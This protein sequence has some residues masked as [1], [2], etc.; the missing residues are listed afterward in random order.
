MQSIKRDG[1]RKLVDVFMLVHYSGGSGL[2]ANV[3][4][5]LEKTTLNTDKNQKGIEQ[6]ARCL[7]QLAEK[8]AG[9]AL[10]AVPA[11]I[12]RKKAIQAKNIPER[13]RFSLLVFN[14]N[15]QR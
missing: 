15:S 11:H 7:F 14:K 3:T 6:T 2:S 13:Q 10:I 12:N 5:W 1:L 4:A 8:R 9:T